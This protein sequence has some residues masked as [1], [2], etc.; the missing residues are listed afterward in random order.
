M[1]CATDVLN[2]MLSFGCL[3]LSWP[4]AATS[5]MNVHFKYG[6]IALLS[7]EAVSFVLGFS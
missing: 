3:N 2:R 6:S 5:R 7:F 4:G 1:T